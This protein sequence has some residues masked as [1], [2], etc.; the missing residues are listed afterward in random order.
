[1]AAFVAL[2][3]TVAERRVRRRSFNVPAGLHQPAESYLAFMVEL[4]FTATGG[5]YKLSTQVQVTPDAIRPQ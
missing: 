1:V 2:P 3:P 5:D 4:T